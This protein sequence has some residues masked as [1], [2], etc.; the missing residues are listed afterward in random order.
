LAALD[1]I[2][3]PEDMQKLNEFR[4]AEFD[5]VNVDW[6]DKGGISI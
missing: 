4:S 1:F 2:I 6:N 3:E 5:S